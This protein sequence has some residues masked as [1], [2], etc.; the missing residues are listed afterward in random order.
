MND[1]MNSQLFKSTRF[2]QGVLYLSCSIGIAFGQPTMVGFWELEDSSGSSVAVDSMGTSNGIVRGDP[3]LEF[4]GVTA[5]TYAAEFDGSGDY[6]EIPHDDAFLLDEGSVVFWFR[7]GATPARAEL[8]SKDSSGNDTGGQ[9]TIWVNSSSR[10]YVRFQSVSADYYCLS[11]SI[12]Q[13]Q[14]HHF[15]FVF[16]TGGMELYI[17]GVLEDTDSY[18]GGMGT[19]SGGT[20]NYEPMVLGANTWGSGNLV[21]TPLEQYFTGTIDQVAL[22][23]GRLSANTV[24]TQANITVESGHLF[25]DISTSSGFD[26]N[27]GSGINGIHWGDLDDDGDLDAILT[28]SSAKLLWNNAFYGTFVPYSLGSTSRQGAM[29]DFD[30]DGDLDFWHINL[31]LWENVGSGSLVNQGSSGMS[32]PSNNEN[33]AAIDINADGLIDVVMLSENGNWIGM[34]ITGDDELTGIA[35]EDSIDPYDGLHISGA[36][37]NGDFISTADVNDDGYLD[38]FY[39][40]SSGQLFLSDGDGTYTRSSSAI[41]VTTGGSDKMGSAFGDY[42]NDGD[43]DL[44]VSRYDSGYTGY[45]LRNDGGGVFTDV[46]SASGISDTRNQRGCS[47]GDYDND[48]DLDLAIA[49]QG[50]GL[51]VYENN[52]DG[53]FTFSYEFPSVAGDTVDVCFVD[54]NNDGNLDLSVTRLSGDAVIL[55]NDMV[56]DSYLRVRYVGKQKVNGAGVGVRL[57]IWDSSNTI[58]VARR[59]IGTARGYGGQNP[60]WA[61]FG[62][63]VASGSYTVRVYEP[64]SATSF[65]F[66]VQ[67]ITTSTTFSAQTVSQLLSIEEGGYR[68]RVVQWREIGAN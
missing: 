49:R 24:A 51:I 59:E 4:G 19:T 22:Y 40:Y 7:T 54:V 11:S 37:G 14:W 6:I 18:A 42:D 34:N 2:Y 17:D 38:I 21:A 66:S 16:G 35:F 36:Y 64:G 53:T 23:S 45:L 29:A 60:L 57:E 32:S 63:L 9:L 50:D 3:Q 44:W 26:V 46:S 58:F 8:L 55:R 47:W 10:V 20:G 28:G 62:G 41:S 65:N 67:P 61:H 5:G 31:D 48:G 30:N 43:M 39:H 27:V 56:S 15:A 33:T 25:T 13:G 52:G 1:A 12:T 68:V